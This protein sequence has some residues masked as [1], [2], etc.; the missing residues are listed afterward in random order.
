MLLKKRRRGFTLIELL[1]VIAI[2]GVLMTL[3]AA[4]VMRFTGVGLGSATK[5]NLGKVNA[6]LTDQWKG[7]TDAANRDTLEDTR[8]L[9]H[10][11]YAARARA[12]GTGNSDKA[13]RKAYVQLRQ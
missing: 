12:F 5:T 4:A 7:V 13:V 3:T 9:Q 8:D 6:K 11:A 10:N 2:I 1:V